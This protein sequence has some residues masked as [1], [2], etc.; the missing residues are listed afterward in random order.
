LNN[1]S[2]LRAKWIKQIQKHQTFDSVPITYSVCADHFDSNYIQQSGNRK[3]LKKGS[4]PIYFPDADGHINVFLPNDEDEMQQLATP[5]Q[6]VDV[7]P[8]VNDA[9]LNSTTTTNNPEVQEQK[10]NTIPNGDKKFEISALE[11]NRY[12]QLEI[13]LQ[14]YKGLCEKKAKE[15]K[16]LQDQVAR[17]KRKELKRFAV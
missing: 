15:I 3:I 4:L 1:D 16:H 9:E 10:E 14:K 2:A 5:E 17:L 11:Y 8:P 7:E 12:L 13:Q 6:A